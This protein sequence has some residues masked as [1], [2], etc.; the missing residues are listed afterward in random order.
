MIGPH[1]L[2]HP[3][4]VRHLGLWPVDTMQFKAYGLLAEG[5][6]IS[7]EMITQAKL[8]LE[9]EVLIRVRDMGD[10]N[11]LGF[12]I[13][14]PGDLGLSIAAQWWTQGS[15]LCQHIYRKA[16]DALA[17]MDT[18]NRPVVGCVWEMALIDEEQRAWRRTMMTA[19]PDP[20]VYLAALA[21]AE[22]V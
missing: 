4:Q 22:G 1:E 12:V 6:D 8:F 2:D 9:Q 18:V 21:P 17:P 11:G 13:V 7:D 15:V 16:Y 5:K 10:S 3:R 14:H 20:S 19:T